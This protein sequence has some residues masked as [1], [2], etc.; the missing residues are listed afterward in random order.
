MAMVMA[1]A[2]RQP[3]TIPAIAPGGRPPSLVGPEKRV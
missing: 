1:T 3:T 2:A